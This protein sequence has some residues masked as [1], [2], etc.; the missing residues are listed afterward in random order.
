MMTKQTLLAH[1]SAQFGSHPELVATESLGH[2]LSNSVPARQGL[3]SI[4]QACGLDIGE[5]AQVETE[6][7]GDEGE[8]P[9]LVCS[10][11][12]GSERLLIEAKYWAG[13][14]ANQ[15]V[16]YL[17][18]LPETEDSALLVVAPFERFSELWPELTRRVS[19]AENMALSDAGTGEEFRWASAGY[20]RWLLLISWRLLLGTLASRA[21]AAGDV[22]TV[23]D[24]RQLQGL[25]QLQDAE[26][27]IPVRPEQLGPESPRFILQMIRLVDDV[28]SHVFETEWAARNGMQRRWEGGLF[29]YMTLGGFNSW[30]GLNY[31]YWAKYRETPLWFGFQG[32]EYE[33]E[34]VILRKLKPLRRKD[35]PELIEGELIVPVFVKAGAGH[36]AVV[37]SVVS[38][39]EKIA[40]LLRAS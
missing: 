38:Q 10:D 22:Q 24:I 4:L 2:I 33:N 3:S 37:G 19:E 6:V 12:N 27:F 39:L 1:L 31:D 23:N 7:T 18:R 36:E 17:R 32:N 40:D 20:K 8:R 13:L 29:Q 16:T 35:P 9:D 14:T 34:N 28:S 30:F 15:P 25:A 5:L 11:Q 26:A 21:D